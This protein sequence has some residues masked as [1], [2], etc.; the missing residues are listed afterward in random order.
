MFTRLD[1]LGVAWSLHRHPAV[2][3]V[4]EARELRGDIPAIHV[5]NLFLRDRKEQMWLVTVAESRP[6][7]LRGLRDVLGARGYPSFGSPERLRTYLGVEPGSV[8]PLAAIHDVE[9][10]VRVV[11]DATLPGAPAV[12]AHPNHNAATVVLSGADLVRYLVSTGHEPALL[13]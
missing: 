8:S 9:G 10:R 13:L 2:H 12:G 11:L 5:K 7:D 3:T 4:E 6:I 1:E